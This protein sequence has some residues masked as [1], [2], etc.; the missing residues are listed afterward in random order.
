MNKVI[1]GVLV[2]ILILLGVWL[3]AKP[4]SAP[5]DLLEEELV[6]DVL[7]ELALVREFYIDGLDDFSFSVPVLGVDQGDVVR[8][9]FTN[10]GQM[11]HDFVIEG[12]GVATPILDYGES[13]T[14]EFTASEVGEFE[15]YCSVGEHRERGMV[16]T[17]IVR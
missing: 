12:L 7:D 14:V 5:E 1:I 8:V 15:Y 9:T 13:A 11:P 2:V 6:E 10:V 17:L 3:I 4:V 16:G